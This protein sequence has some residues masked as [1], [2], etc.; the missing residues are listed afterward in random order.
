VKG[1]SQRPMI[2]VASKMDAVDNPET[3][4]ELRRIAAERDMRFIPISSATAQGIDE[5]KYAMT[6]AVLDEKPLESL[7]RVSTLRAKPF[8]GDS[9]RYLIRENIL[10]AGQPSTQNQQNP[11]VSRAGSVAEFWAEGTFVGKGVGT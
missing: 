1:L 6:G 10:A 8:V 3:V 2:L 9:S 7:S 4:D 5:L 11:P